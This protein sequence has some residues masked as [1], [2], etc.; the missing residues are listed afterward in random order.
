MPFV[1]N[2]KNL[3][4]N[5]S[6]ENIDLTK[7]LKRIINESTVFRVPPINKYELITI[8]DCEDFKSFF[9]FHQGIAYKSSGLSLILN[10]F[11]MEKVSKNF[12]IFF[13]IYL[14]FIVIILILMLFFPS[15]LFFTSTSNLGNMIETI[16]QSESA[17]IAIVITL[18]L[19]AVQ[20]TASSYT[21]RVIN[22]FKNSL[23]LWILIMSYLIT[24]TYGLILLK[25]L[26][27]SSNNEIQLWIALLMSIFTIFA[28][29]PF[30]LDMLDLMKPSQI[31]SKLGN[32]INDYQVLYSLE[33][34]NEED[35]IQPLI[36]IIHSSLMKYDY[37]TL[38]RGLN[39]IVMYNK[40]IFTNSKTFEFEKRKLSKCLLEHL[41][42]V[43]NLAV[44]RNDD[45]ATQLIIITI[46]YNML[47]MGPRQ[48]NEELYTAIDVI[49]N[50][51]KLS[52]EKDLQTS[53]FSALNLLQQHSLSKAPEYIIKHIFELYDEFEKQTTNSNVLNQIAGARE[54]FRRMN[55]E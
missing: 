33:K 44:N 47:H 19:V 43:G 5:L 29:I 41:S 38:R 4:K 3:K 42:Q 13:S 10:L 2:T 52:I 22:I 51:A 11:S 27:T 28:L 17:I 1:C 8:N 46:S 54:M 15:N 50:F 31:I 37:G 6:H 35:D 39:E 9:K 16:V 45:D 40:R 25:F 20:L 48:Y 53:T 26:Q 55:E 18:S 49:A 34:S 30:L 14:I 24:M 36:D 21:P 32:E 12:K 23:S 7:S